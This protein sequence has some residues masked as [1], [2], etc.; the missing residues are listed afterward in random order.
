MGRWDVLEELILK[1]HNLKLGL[2]R[3]NIIKKSIRIEGLMNLCL[4]KWDLCFKENIGLTEQIGKRDWN[5]K[6]QIQ[7][8]NLTKYIF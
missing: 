7:V 8:I 5:D 4:V 6:R 3:M 2:H 1:E